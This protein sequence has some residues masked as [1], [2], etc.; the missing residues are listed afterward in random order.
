[1]GEQ[2]QPEQDCPQ[3]VLFTDMV[4]AGAG[5]LLAADSGEAGIEQVAEKLPAGRRLIDL[6]AQPLGDMVA[7]RLVGMERAM[8]AI[9]LA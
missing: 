6:D 7:A 2:R 4:R 8:P 3:P 1:M 9:P 5:A